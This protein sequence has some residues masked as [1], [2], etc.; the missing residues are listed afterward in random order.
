MIAKFNTDLLCQDQPSCS[1][2]NSFNALVLLVHSSQ[3]LVKFSEESDIP[4]ALVV[5]IDPMNDNFVFLE[6][7]ME[8]ASIPAT[9]WW[10]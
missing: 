8:H 9:A 10:A 4:L 2:K 7:G 3:D 1:Y 6:Y 5:L